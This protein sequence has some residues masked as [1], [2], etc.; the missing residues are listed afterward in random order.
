MESLL[1]DL[2]ALEFDWTVEGAW[3]G[4]VSQGVLGMGLG[5]VAYNFT[6]LYL[7][8]MVWDFYG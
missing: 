1:G 2:L 4:G 3:L 7:V 8:C 6:V 5:H